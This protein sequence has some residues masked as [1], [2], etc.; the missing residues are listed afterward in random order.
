MSF[1]KVLTYLRYAFTGELK[2]GKAVT[3]IETEKLEL[4]SMEQDVDIQS[5][6]DGDKGPSLPLT[7]EW[8]K[9]FIDLMIPTKND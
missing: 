7:L 2:K 3:Y 9:D 4:I 5:R 6:I 1:S 8:E